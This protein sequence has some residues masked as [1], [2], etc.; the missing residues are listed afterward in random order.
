MRTQHGHAPTRNPEAGAILIYNLVVIFIFSLVAVSLLGYATAQLRTIRSTINSELA[1]HIAESGVN[2]YQWRLA[3]FPADFW[4]G[5]AST[6]PGP[7]THDFIDKD[8]NQKV[9]EYQLTV[10]PPETGSTVVTI[11][12]TGYTTQNPNTK[13]TVTARYG[14][15]SLAKYAFLTHSDV[16]IGDTENVSGEMHANGG[17]RFDGT[18]NAPIK[19]A[20]TTYQ[21]PPWSGCNPTTTKPGIWGAA[22]TTTQAFWQLS[23]PNVDFSTM[24][25]DLATIKSNAQSGGVYLPPSNAQ[26]YSL[27]FST[28]STTT[29]LTVYKVTSLRSHQTGWDVNGASHNE[30]LDY[31]ARSFQFT[32]TTPSNGLIYV[33]DRTWVEGGLRSRV[34]VAAAKLPYNPSTAPSILIPASLRYNAKDGTASLGL[35][36]Q[37]DILVTYFAPSTLEINAALIAQNGSAQRYYFSGNTK[38]SI[39]IYGSVASYGL[40]TWSWVDGGGN[41]TSGYCSTSTVYDSSLLY[42]PPPSFPLSNDGYQQI[43]WASS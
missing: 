5:N 15:P 4:D 14:V 29:M 27:V 3:H 43:T 6:T 25:G 19:S 28:T 37:K 16:W 9:G 2:Y 1:F 31:N 39:T 32:T 40:W 23:Q 17:I 30:D 20:K 35:L 22:P 21:C 13:R 8:T 36:A 41:C 38:T 12:A 34:T 18:G 42:S 26:G 10:T 7:Y 24:T 33:E 11:Q